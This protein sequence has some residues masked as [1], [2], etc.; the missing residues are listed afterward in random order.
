MPESDTFWL[1]VTNIALG[2]VVALSGLAS[3]VLLVREVLA[4]WRKH[5]AE[6]A[7]LDSDMRKL[8]GEHDRLP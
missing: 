3:L 5:R 4:K 2:I 1:S 7:E 6:D 8:F